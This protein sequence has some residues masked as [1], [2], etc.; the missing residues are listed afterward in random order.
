MDQETRLKRLTFRGLHRGN[1]E[2][3]IV[4]GHFV[5]QGIDALSDDQIDLFEALLEESDVDIWNW[6]TGLPCPEEY[7]SLIE[8]IRGSCR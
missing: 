8:M 7:R 4:F 6:L 3:D 2:M 5:A 1:K